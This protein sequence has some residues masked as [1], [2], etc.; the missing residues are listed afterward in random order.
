[1]STTRER[2]VEAAFRLFDERGYA[3]TTVDDVAERAGVGR[4][5]FFRAFRSKEDVIFPDHDALLAAIR[6]RLATATPATTPIAVTEAARLVLLQYLGEGKRAQ[7]RYALTR[8][9]PALRAREIAGQRQYQETFRGFLHGWMGGATDTA[10][11]AELMANAIVTAHNH[12]LRRWLRGG[13]TEDAVEREFDAAMAD[14]LHL[15][16]NRTDS[17]HREASLVVLHTSRPLTELLPALRRL[18]EPET[19]STVQDESS[20]GHHD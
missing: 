11:R 4:T 19:I 15:F 7:T 20:A 3:E 5:T 1:L 9:V 12:V 16:Q 6:D 14:V 17:E 8:S 2:M 10:L 18:V 13:L